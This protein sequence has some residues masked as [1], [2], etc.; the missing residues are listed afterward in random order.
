MKN[1]QSNEIIAAI[2][3]PLGEG[4][5]GIVRLSGKGSLKIADQ[6]FRPVHKKVK[7]S[8]FLSYSTHYGYIVDEGK[9][10][11]EVIL[12]VMRSPKTY[13]REDI[14]E[15][16]CHGGM[17]A[18][19]KILELVVKKGVR[20]AEP[21]EFTK[22]A[23]L[24]G[25]IDLV[26]AEAVADIIRAKTDMGL[27]VALEQLE[28]GLSNE[29]KKIRS[30]IMDLLALI[31]TLIDFTEEEIGK[32][33]VKVRKDIKILQERLT[34]LILSFDKGNLLKEGASVA[35]IGRPNV[36][37]SSFM[38]ALLGKERAIVTSIPGTTTD[39]I[40]EIIDVDGAKIRIIDT[41]G[42]S[43]S[44]K[45]TVKTNNLI[46]LEG[47]KRAKKVLNDAQFLFFIIDGSRP[48]SKEDK[49]LF[50]EIKDSKVIVLVNK[51]DLPRKIKNSEIEAFHSNKVIEIS[52]KNCINIDKVRNTIS[53]MIWSGKINFESETIL[54][55]VRHKELLVKALEDLKQAQA[56]KFRQEELVAQDLR[57]AASNLAKITGEES[58]ED[59]L[60][61]IFS[62]FCIG[63]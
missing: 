44:R 59:I 29:V 37:K 4:G 12:T 42:I 46:E 48:L 41:A 57:Q 49:K 8:E 63:K 9:R 6:I 34:R 10:L 23:F 1:V 58:G 20:I 3:T 31:E 50:K 18:S 38:N 43:Y 7:P 45:N 35:I 51:T 62:Q 53:R 27:K 24:S 14:V 55:N 22:R 56:K 39:T 32:Q 2:S 13:T 33:A 52:A 30:E 16:N 28:G 15:I 54:T 40:E 17:V 47:M 61:R 19:K 11:D 60:D 5:I 26:Q 25:R 36:G 21:G